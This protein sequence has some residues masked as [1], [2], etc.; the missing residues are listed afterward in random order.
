MV[1]T[2]ADTI[3]SP[4]LL[5][6]PSSVFPTFESISINHLLLLWSWVVLVGWSNP[7]R[8]PSRQRCYVREDRKGGGGE[9]SELGIQHSH[10]WL[11][12]L[13]SSWVKEG[14][15]PHPLSTQLSTSSSP[16]LQRGDRDRF[17]GPRHRF[18]EVFI[19]KQA[20]QDLHTHLFQLIK[21]H[22]IN[23]CTM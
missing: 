17:R 4:S 15:G 13:A 16:C 14:G 18:L 11:E 20:L 7:F 23:K 5:V 2:S 3:S 21:N 10:T 22:H 9:G 1:E 8:A 19:H 6:K 12:S